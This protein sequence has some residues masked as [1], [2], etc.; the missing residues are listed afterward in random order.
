MSNNNGKLW[1]FKRG[2]S[3][4]PKVLYVPPKGGLPNLIG[5][6]AICGVRDSAGN[7][8]AVN[9]LIEA[10]GVSI[11]LSSTPEETIKWEFGLSK[12]DVYYKVG[13]TVSAT[14][15]LDFEITENVAAESLI[16]TL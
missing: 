6:T 9:A 2:T 16:A 14:E 4:A 10:N 8:F 11:Q 15:T 1:Q 7:R 12:L 5:A 13:T 3:F